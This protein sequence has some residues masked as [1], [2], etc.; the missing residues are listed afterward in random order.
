MK[1]LNENELRS[2]EGGSNKLPDSFKAIVIEY[3]GILKNVC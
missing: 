1:N 3:E 2:I